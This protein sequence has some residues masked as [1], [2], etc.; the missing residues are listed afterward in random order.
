MSQNSGK[1]VSVHLS[2][3]GSAPSRAVLPRV[4]PQSETGAEETSLSAKLHLS[5]GNQV[6]CAAAG[7]GALGGLGPI[8]SRAMLRSVAGVQSES[9]MLSNRA[10]CQA[11]LKAHKEDAPEDLVA[12]V[13]GKS[14]EAMP[15][16]VRERMERV[17]GHDFGHVRIHRDA[18]AAQAAT[19]LSAHAFAVGSDVFFGAGE[20]SPG[21][22]EGDRLLI[23]EL[24]HVVQHD[25]GQ[26]SQSRGVSSPSD[27]A[28]QEAYAMEDRIQKQLAVV[29][30]VRES[31]IPD[32][33]M[34][35]GNLGSAA[36]NA[37]RTEGAAGPLLRSA[38]GAVAH[39]ED[40]FTDPDRVRDPQTGASF[41]PDQ[42]CSD[43]EGQDSPNAAPGAAGD[44]GQD[45][46]DE[47]PA[48]GGGASAGSASEGQDGDGDGQSTA[49]SESPDAAGEAPG[50]APAMLMPPKDIPVDVPTSSEPATLS[51]PAMF[52][53]PTFMTESSSGPTTAP[54]VS[55][56]DP[57]FLAVLALS[58]FTTSV[59]SAQLEANA[60]AKKL[61]GQID[62]A[63]AVS[64]S[65]V[66]KQV[67]AAGAT[68]SSAFDTTRQR[69][70]LARVT[71]IDGITGKRRVLEEQINATSANYTSAVSTAIKT[72]KGKVPKE[73][74]AFAASLYKEM[75]ATAIQ[76][77]GTGAYWKYQCV[78]AGLK[79]KKRQRNL[80][81]GANGKQA[82][83][84]RGMTAEAVG[85]GFG[86]SIRK[87]AGK[88]DRKMFRM[89]KDANSFSRPIATSFSSQLDTLGTTAADGFGMLS[90]QTLEGV[91]FLCDSSTQ[92][93]ESAVDSKMN[94]LSEEE[95]KALGKL[96]QMGDQA[97][98]NIGKSG[99]R[100]KSAI[101]ER[102]NGLSDSYAKQMNQL[103]G[104]TSGKEAS[105]QGAIDELRTGFDAAHALEL[106]NLRELGKVGL[107]KLHEHASL[108]LAAPKK[109]ALAIAKGAETL[110]TEVENKAYGTLG[111]VTA[112]MDLG[113]LECVGNMGTLDT[114]VR[115]HI[116]GMLTGLKGS[117][118]AQQKAVKANFDKI[119]G[120][121]DKQYGKHVKAKLLPTIRKHANEQ[122]ARVPE[123]WKR[124]VKKAV[125]IAVAATFIIATAGAGAAAAGVLATIAIG[126]IGGAIGGLAVKFT[127][128][129][130]Q[131]MY[132]EGRKFSEIN[133]KPKAYLTAA[134]TGAAGGAL[135]L[136]AGKLAARWT[137]DALGTTL[138]DLGAN[139]LASGLT[140][141][142]EVVLLGKSFNMA[143]FLL[144]TG[145]ATGVG[146]GFRAFGGQFGKLKLKFGKS[147]LG[148]KLGKKL[149]GQNPV[150]ANPKSAASK[151]GT[152]SAPD[153]PAAKPSS[154]PAPDAP[155]AKPASKT[156]PDAPSAKPA[157]KPAPDVPAA[158][159]ASKPAPDAPSAKPAS[160]PAPDA[161]AAKPASKPAPDAP[162]ASKPKFAN[163]PDGPAGAPSRVKG[164]PQ[165]AAPK[166]GGKPQNYQA[167]K[168]KA[169]RP[170]E[171]PGHKKPNTPTS[172]PKK[173]PDV[174]SQKKDTGSDAS[175]KGPPSGKAWDDPKMTADDLIA[176]YRHRYPKTTM[177]DAKLRAAFKAGKRLNP[178][179]GKL[180]KPGPASTPTSYTKHGRGD[181]A[182]WRPFDGDAGYGKVT[183]YRKQ[184]RAVYDGPN[185]KSKITE[186]EHVLPRST[187]ADITKNPK[188]GRSDYGSKDYQNTDTVRV[189]RDTALSK[190]RGD[191]AR[192]ADL[193]KKGEP[194]D[195][196]KEAMDA[197]A[198]TKA[199]RDRT[200]APVTDKEIDEATIGSLN[201]LFE[202]SRN[203]DII[204][205]VKATE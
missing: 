98:A 134:L 79:E 31:G 192:T 116:S 152:G 67:E 193:R 9:P 78:M 199:A 177:T 27:P 174:P 182:E 132:L 184:D 163:P 183:K 189:P 35:P 75:A 194:I 133:F 160:K 175:K 137:L 198:R 123:E 117:L 81:Q 17:F 164:N 205:K 25:E 115:G 99:T 73:T 65:G 32:A 24:T 159:P 169:A 51:P 119:P 84:I 36:H 5:L 26:L 22:S 173:K 106:E 114:K 40:D 144:S 150:A 8:L 112:N 37:P 142:G 161:P 181:G 200:N 113:F 23:H 54:T 155:S 109:A 85:R 197:N 126:A 19:S 90:T 128:D 71:A 49:P 141:L 125:V 129:V 108:S 42:D 170:S 4:L 13:A 89:G 179:T 92:S 15:S 20:Y 156:A 38:D 76:V 47:A 162:A 188:T 14:G 153:A 157:S 146:A 148:K 124:T 158:K 86:S 147:S 88:I 93:I 82:L 97:K 172:G 29:D 57:K 58:N 61:T 143:E 72:A 55:G 53:P 136:G 190:T 118:K 165:T 167:P 28:E 94:K 110:A 7:G 166:G 21:T 95:E 77:R 140:Q 12:D 80:G 122:A 59:T 202:T 11:M 171:D 30:L 44:Q 3:A 127:E 186:N 68:V 70:E 151:A 149:G 60:L 201:G 18:K 10:M 64:L 168:R 102:A 83:I 87:H 187:A 74:A 121:L 178:K 100:V 195:V 43:T 52:T 154:K 66:D 6:V 91:A 1:G 39:D 96:G 180:K 56:P 135:A 196:N 191:N 138:L 16:A 34:R 130:M 69:M 103:A 101:A 145:L 120:G 104:A 50:G 139:A 176:D 62:A 111:E 2:P 131:G 41:E 48:G 107:K 33:G 63:I 203:R 46:P 185:N 204:G 105:E 45:D